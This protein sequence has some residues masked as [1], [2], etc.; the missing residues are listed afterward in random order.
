MTEDTLTLKKSEKVETRT[1][2]YI[3]AGE[4]SPNVIKF[5]GKV[6]MV[7]GE[8]V[9][10]PVTPE[11]KVVLEKLKGV[12]TVIEGKVE[13]KQLQENDIKAKEKADKQR[14]EDKVTNQKAMKMLGKNK[15]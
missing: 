7:R 10:I 12:S 2:T 5:M 13:R 6:D 14:A 1:F 9:E 15:G 4:D 11:F 3:G 8:P